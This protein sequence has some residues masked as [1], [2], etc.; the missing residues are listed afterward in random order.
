M[1]VHWPFSGSKF[2]QPLYS[3][4]ASCRRAQLMPQAFIMR[5]VGAEAIKWQPKGELGAS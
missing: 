5:M 3:V 1:N 2:H 4:P